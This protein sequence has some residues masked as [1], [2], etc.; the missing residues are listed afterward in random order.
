MKKILLG[1]SALA[2]AGAFAGQ[3]NAATWDLDWGGYFESSI[4]YASVDGPAGTD[5]DGVDVLQD[6]EIQFTP[7]ITL[8]NGLTFGVDI[9]LE[10]NASSNGTPDVIDESFIFIKGS[11][12]QVLIGSENSAGYKMSYGAPDVTWININSGSLT[13]FIPD[14]QPS[15]FRGVGGTSFV[16]VARNNDS[17]RITY[18]SPRFSGFQVGASYARDGNQDN[19]SQVDINQT[20]TLHDIFD[21]GV[22]YVNSFGAFDVAVAG[23]YGT[24]TLEN[25]GANGGDLDPEVYAFGLNLGYAGVTIGGSYARSDDDI[26]IRN[27]DFFDLGVSYKTGPWGASLT[28]SKGELDTGDERQQYLAGVT[29]KLGPGVST[30][31]YIGYT[32]YEAGANTGRSDLDGFVIGTGFKLNF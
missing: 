4:G 18:F 12:G 22:N 19:S 17:Q 16:E 29:Y 10:G 28:Y 21:V 8:D 2:M 15:V 6:A 25:A 14:S 24:G 13:S 27:G 5:F 11:F 30:G 23:R 26:A 1:T 7:S 20:G 9:Q 32:D 3:A 31:A